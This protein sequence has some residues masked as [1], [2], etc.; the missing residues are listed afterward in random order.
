MEWTLMGHS[1]GA[2]AAT[3]LFRESLCD[4]NNNKEKSESNWNIT[5]GKK[6]VLWGVAAFVNLAT[7]LS[8]EGEAQILILQGTNDE[9]VEMMQ[10]K[11][12]EL[13]AF[14]PPSTRTEHIIGGTHEGF[15]SYGSIFDSGTTK[16]KKE[17]RKSIPL[18]RQHKKACDATVRFLSFR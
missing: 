2:F 11:E 7:D 8:A 15:A 6:L 3:Q 1:M 17:S 13:E 9:F 18:D 12:D 5:L 14:F 4:S 10:S 16:R